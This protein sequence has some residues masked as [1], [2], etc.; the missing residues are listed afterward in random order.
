[1]MFPLMLSQT[2]Q[3]SLSVHSKRSVAIKMATDMFK[4][5]GNEQFPLNKA[6]G[7]LGCGG[8]FEA[9]CNSKCQKNDG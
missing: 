5:A 8:Y 1:M 2:M 4:I 6:V 9:H 7:G 3:L